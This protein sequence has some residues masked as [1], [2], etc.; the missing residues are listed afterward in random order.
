MRKRGGARLKGSR[1]API[2]SVKFAL[3]PLATVYDRLYS[4][5]HRHSLERIVVGLSVLGFLTHLAHVALARNLANPPAILAAAGNNYLSAIYT[6]F[7][8]I[9]FYEVLIL[10]SAIPQSTT[11]SLATQFEIVS[12]IFIRGFFKEIA[13]IDMDSLRIHEL[14]PAF[15][16]AGT[17]LTMFLLVAIFHRLTRTRPQAA[18][19]E[20]AKFIERKKAVAVALTVAFVSMGAYAV[21]QFAREALA[22]VARG[23]GMLADSKPAFYSDMFTVMIFTDVLILILSLMV[24]DRYELVFRNAAFVIATIL[25]RFSLTADYPYGAGIG[26][27]GMLFGIVTLAVYNYCTR[28]TVAS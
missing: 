11:Q 17:G 5:Q 27:I 14:V 20:L 24:S 1:R 22:I 21:I 25:I 3:A 12:L 8:I 26:V 28:A 13:V 6:P 7:S 9:L 4:E 18:S 16:A 19:P 23:S 10:I 15:V 2:L